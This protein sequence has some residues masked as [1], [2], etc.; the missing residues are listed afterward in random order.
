M[1]RFQPGREQG[2]G[3]WGGILCFLEKTL[4]PWEREIGEESGDRTPLQG[5]TWEPVRD[6]LGAQKC[7][8]I[9]GARNKDHGKLIIPTV[10]TAG[11]TSQRSYKALKVVPGI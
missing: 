5:V 10:I 3:N 9:P 8:G 1:H 4:R 7:P 6:Q 2:S 11:L